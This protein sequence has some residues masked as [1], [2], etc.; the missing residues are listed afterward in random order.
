VKE[1]VTAADLNELSDYG[2][3]RLSMYDRK[4]DM[5]CHYAVLSEDIG[6]RTVD[7]YYPALTIGNMIEFLDLHGERQIVREVI[8]NW[9]KGEELADKLWERVKD[10]LEHPRKAHEPFI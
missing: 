4:V 1:H 10:I 5:D 2:L 6:D 3:Q 7:R 8:A 9:K